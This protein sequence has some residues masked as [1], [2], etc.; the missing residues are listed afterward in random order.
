MT[1]PTTA[2]SREEMLSNMGRVKRHIPYDVWAAIVALIESAGT[3]GE[4]NKR[5][6]DETGLGKTNVQGAAALSQG[7][8]QPATAL[9][10][11]KNL[12][13][14]DS[15]APTPPAA[16]SAVEEA[17]E[18]IS[19]CRSN[20]VSP[21]DWDAA[22]AVLR[23]AL[24]AENERL[25]ADKEELRKMG[26]TFMDTIAKLGKERNALRAENEKFRKWLDGMTSNRNY[27]EK[28]CE[29]AEAELDEARSTIVLREKSNDTIQ[30]ALEKAEGQ[31]AAQ[32]P[33]VEAVGWNS[34]EVISDELWHL[35]KVNLSPF[36][37][38]G[39]FDAIVFIL[40]AALALREGEK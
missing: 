15:P 31:L 6:G 23:A 1:N 14:A 28:K 40:R 13:P 9:P 3:S 34:A 2:P 7:L 30:A 10:V 24:T 19:F 22:L 27:W 25:R 5:A 26:D 39:P 20:Y 12:T 21:S 33:L 37:M 35:E 4:E 8:S 16:P 11:S 29:E 32:R 18:T 17:M 36:G 38:P